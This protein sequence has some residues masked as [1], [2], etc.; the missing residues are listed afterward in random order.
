[1][2]DSTRAVAAAFYFAPEFARCRRAETELR[3]RGINLP[4]APLGSYSFGAVADTVGGRTRQRLALHVHHGT[5]VV[6]SSSG[7]LSVFALGREL[8]P[9]GTLFAV[10]VDSASQRAIVLVREGIVA[11]ADGALRAGRGQA[12]LFG[13]GAPPQRITFD[14]T[15][16]NEVQ[17]HS[18][19]VWQPAARVPPWR[20]AAA[21]AG[22]AARA[23]VTTYAIHELIDDKPKRSRANV[24]VKIPL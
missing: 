18:R 23:L 13:G 4:K 5:V 21:A 10:I 17:Y 7:P 6:T 11:T 9:V 8:R 3:Y 20:I 14:K 2:E 15:L 12:L 24:V 19:T 1:V 16:G 22:I